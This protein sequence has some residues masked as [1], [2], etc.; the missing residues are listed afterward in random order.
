MKWKDYFLGDIGLS[1]QIYRLLWLLAFKIVHPFPASMINETIDGQE[2]LF[3]P[4]LKTKLIG[5]SYQLPDKTLDA[6][7]YF[8]W[9]VIPF[10]TQ[11]PFRHILLYAYIFRTLG[12]S[13][14]FYTKD[15]KYIR[16]FPDVFISWY[17]LFY[18]TKYLGIKMSPTTTLVMLI[19]TAIVRIV[20]ER[21]F[22]GESNYITQFLLT[23]VPEGLMVPG[24]LILVVVVYALNPSK[25]FSPAV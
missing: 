19:T 15:K 10:V 4:S 13:M 25:F 12:L 5:S 21:I 17:F 22:L 2:I 1:F 8:V 24:F 3:F 20:F 6:I 11:E 14:Y 23:K 7:G 16:C 18:G 9:L